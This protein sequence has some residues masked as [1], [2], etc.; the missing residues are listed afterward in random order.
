MDVSTVIG[1][2]FWLIIYLQV[3]LIKNL[4]ILIFCFVD[5]GVP[6]VKQDFG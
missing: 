1:F 3:V 5:L 4:L 6:H 2:G